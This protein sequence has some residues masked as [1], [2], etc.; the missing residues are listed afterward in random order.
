MEV[1]GLDVN[2]GS[3]LAARH[4]RDD[5][6]YFA[7]ALV[8]PDRTVGIAA[9]P[10]VADM[11]P[12]VQ[13]PGQALHA[14]AGRCQPEVPLGDEADDIRDIPVHVSEN[15]VANPYRELGYFSHRARCA[16]AVSPDDVVPEGVQTVQ[17]LAKAPPLP[18]DLEAD[19]LNDV[20]QLQ[21]P[22][23]TPLGSDADAITEPVESL[24]HHGT[25]F[26]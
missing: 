9:V 23:G 22:L 11:A 6:H 1:A 10:Q 16:T 24:P 25:A 15:G 17:K 5:P 4:H 21:D 8:A 13:Q 14:L 7:D 26:R 18:L 20:A 2:V 12:S 19:R 3:A